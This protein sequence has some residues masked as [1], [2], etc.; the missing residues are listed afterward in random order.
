MRT[1][2]K[3]RAKPEGQSIEEIHVDVAAFSKTGSIFQLHFVPHRRGD[4]NTNWR[5]AVV[6]I[7]VIPVGERGGR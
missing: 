6:V 2:L 3:S 1:H 4:P 5:V 7:N